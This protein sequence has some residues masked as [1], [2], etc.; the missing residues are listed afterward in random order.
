MEGEGGSGG[1]KNRELVVMNTAYMSRLPLPLQ[2]DVMLLYNQVVMTYKGETWTFENVTEERVN[3][4][5]QMLREGGEGGA[6]MMTPTTT[7]T[8]PTTTRPRARARAMGEI[9]RRRSEVRV[10]Q[11]AVGGANV[12]TLL[13]ALP[14]PNDVPVESGGGRRGMRRTDGDDGVGGTAAK[15]GGN[16]DHL[17]PNGLDTNKDG[18]GDT[19]RDATAGESS[20]RPLET[21]SI[22][23]VSRE[24]RVH[25]F[26][27]KRRE[28]KMKSGAV[29]AVPPRGDMGA[30]ADK[31]VQSLSRQEVAMRQVRVKGK[32]AKTERRAEDV[33]TH[34][35]H[36]KCDCSE[37]PVMRKGP[38]G[39]L[40]LCNA[41]GLV[42]AKRGVLREIKPQ[43]KTMTPAPTQ[44]SPS[45][46]SRLVVDPI[47]AAGADGAATGPLTTTTASGAK[48]KR[49]NEC[50]DDNGD[51]EPSA[52][53]L[54]SPLGSNARCTDTRTDVAPPSVFI[55]D[56]PSATYPL[57]VVH[58]P[59]PPSPL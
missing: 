14:L 34:C 6:E 48:R 35:V 28:Q 31:S 8:T 7:P 50:D 15:A 38:S 29:P 55:A 13:R 26:K 18:G 54:Y 19:L 51:A 49:G 30:A 43:R 46:P 24:E 11:A 21:A 5:V 52:S 33:C 44:L 12:D 56:P 3:R 9:Q 57:P 32:F 39:A 45:P 42:W 1:K 4:V 27:E 40:S 20:H 37:T 17:A 23:P 2:M 53:P 47:D 22:Q 36:C 25:R 41:C 16:D 58:S 59:P 10:P